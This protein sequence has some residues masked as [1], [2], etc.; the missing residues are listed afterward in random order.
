M[1]S[2]LYCCAKLKQYPTVVLR[3]QQQSMLFEWENGLRL[4]NRNDFYNRLMFMYMIFV[5]WLLHRIENSKIFCL[6]N[7][8]TA[9]AGPLARSLTRAL[10][11]MYSVC[12]SIFNFC[13][14]AWM[15]LYFT[16][17]YDPP[18]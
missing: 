11:S 7:I 15:L 17:I 1:R 8:L 10:G 3:Q 9:L 4:Y 18:E 14:C 13:H 2:L 12:I 5:R 16:D 6:N